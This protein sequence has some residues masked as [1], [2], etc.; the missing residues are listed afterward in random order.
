M[1]YTWRDI[2]GWFDFQ[3]VYEQAT[4]EAPQTGAHFVEV[5]VLFGRSSAFM[6]EKI[7]ESGKDIQFSAVDLFAWTGEGVERE[8]ER[9][10]GCLESRMWLERLKKLPPS[11]T[12]RFFAS[13]L[14]TDS[15]S[16]VDMVPVEGKVFASCYPVQSFD[17]VFIDAA[18]TYEDTLDLLFAFKSKVKIG[19]V[20]AGHDH[21]AECHGVIKAVAEVLGDVEQRG[22]CFWW[23]KP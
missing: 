16:E 2:P 15:W 7:R 18:H 6:A 12:A 13:M 19:G 14:A 9:A 23:R 21:N 3:D 8:L 22:N 4:R 1:P 17:F 11:L 20:L 5:G 10:S